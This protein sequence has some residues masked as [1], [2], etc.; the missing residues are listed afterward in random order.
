MSTTLIQ[1]IFWSFILPA[2]LLFTNL[3]QNIPSTACDETDSKSLYKNLANF[4]FK[5]RFSIQSYTSFFTPYNYVYYLK[6]SELKIPF[7]H[8][9]SSSK[10]VYHF[11]NS[12]GYISEQILI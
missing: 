6:Y 12:S 3:S 9:V 11:Q 7:R 5:V 2:A 4:K 8:H 10:L 1:I